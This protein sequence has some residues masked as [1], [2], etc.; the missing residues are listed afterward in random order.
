MR[1]NREEAMGHDLTAGHAFL[2]NANRRAIGK[3][4]ERMYPIDDCPTFADLLTR[5]A[6]AERKRGSRKR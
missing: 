1:A 3:N 6:A 2:T 5:I 4:L